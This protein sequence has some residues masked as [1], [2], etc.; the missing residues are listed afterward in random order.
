MTGTSG[1]L[2]RV[3]LVVEDDRPVGQ[4]LATAIND[5]AGYRA[6]HV[7][8]PGE[9]LKVLGAVRADV[10]VLD[11][12]LPGMSGLELYDRVR[13][14]R[15]YA[16]LPVVVQTANADEHVA[17]LRQRG[18]ATYVRKPFD[19]DLVVDY[20]KRLAPPLDSAGV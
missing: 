19:V 11:L 20:V 16:R 6:L 9:A 15:R 18:I 10:L 1:T 17:A 14:D 3:V 12:A 5:E 7:E 2:Q 8:T 4:V 13:R